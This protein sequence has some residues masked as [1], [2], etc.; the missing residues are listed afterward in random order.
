LGENGGTEHNHEAPKQWKAQKIFVYI[1][2]PNSV[3]VF[4]TLD[5]RSFGLGVSVDLDAETHKGRLKVALY[6]SLR[7]QRVFASLKCCKYVPQK[8]FLGML[9]KEAQEAETYETP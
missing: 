9:F 7:L 2:L 8:L 5:L 4:L 6:V 3:Q 1:F